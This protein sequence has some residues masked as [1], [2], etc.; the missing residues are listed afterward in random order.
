MKVIFLIPFIPKYDEY[1]NQSRPQWNWNTDTGTWVGIW[2]Y[3]W[4]DLIGKS[5]IKYSNTIEFEVW[6]P[7]LR[8]DKIYTAVLDERLVHKN[9][10]A[11]IKTHQSGLK[12]SVYFYSKQII[13][14]AKANNNESVILMVPAT[15]FNP[16]IKIL[17]KSMKKATI[18]HYNFLN[19]KL[20]LPTV[21]RCFNPLRLLHRY[22][23]SKHKFNELRSMKYLLTQNDG[24]E[25]LDILRDKFDHIRLF[26]F[27]LG[28]DHDYWQQDKTVEEARRE[29]DIPL[30]K[31]VIFLSQ[32]L[33]PEYQID[34]FIQAISEVKSK[35][36]Y[37]C[38]ISGHGTIEYESYLKGLLT[39]NR[40]EDLIHFVGYIS[41]ADLKNYFIAC[42]V[43]ATV[44]IMFAGST[45][46]VKA[47]TMNKPVVHVTIAGTYEYLKKYNAGVYLDPVDYDQWIRVFEDVINGVKIRTVP[48]EK[49]VDYYSWETTAKEILY[50]IEKAKE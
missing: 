13:K 50:A 33:V 1:A 25:D 5:L 4:G 2:G 11:R 9:F 17:M 10:P 46:A 23:L 15:V 19:T 31:F 21:E 44:P 6:Q 16:L 37:V 34:K 14:Y 45:G 12:R 43:F 27:K 47:M 28:L 3:D 18:I 39:K 26:F 20:L 29:L 49:V 42:D 7:D 40:V 30:S 48:R 8:A 24:S 38:Y 35:K 32:R 41:D 22:L 36:N